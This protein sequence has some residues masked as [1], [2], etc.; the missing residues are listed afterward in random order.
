MKGSAR[1]G[2][3]FGLTS[4][5]V[6]TLGMIVGLNAW[7]GSKLVVIGGILSIAIAD[8][9]SDALGIHVSEESR[10]G[11]DPKKVWISTFSTLLWKFV[12]SLTF[13][14][15]ILLFN[16]PWSILVSIIWGL[17]ALA[18]F[19]YSIAKNR[20][21]N[22][23]YV[24]MEHLVIAIVVIVITHLVGRWLSLSFV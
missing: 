20:K 11:L 5:I 8:S 9:F 21:D 3:S 2:F 1:K 18:L 24:I 13:I 12:F 7:T 4:G 17:F 6:T 19:S 16:Y 14:V 23:F 22:A 10:P 15:P